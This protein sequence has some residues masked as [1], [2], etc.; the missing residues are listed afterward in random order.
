MRYILY[1]LLVIVGSCTT[2]SREKNQQHTID[3]LANEIKKRDSVEKEEATPVKQELRDSVIPIVI[4]ENNEESK[5]SDAKK[6]EQPLNTIS[7]KTGN[8]DVISKED[9]IVKEEQENTDNINERNAVLKKV[10]IEKPTFKPLLLGG[11][12]E[13][14]FN[15]Y[16]N[17]DYKLEEAIL[18]VHYIRADGSEIKSETKILKDI[19]PH[20]RM[21]LTAPDHAQSGKE[22]KVTLE[23]VHCNAIGLCFYSTDAGRSGD[24]YKCR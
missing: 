14:K 3:S 23:A 17:Y 9:S 12:K 16:N 20:S 24:P 21:E 1:L 6:K 8:V 4:E 7:K 5:V 13:I 10:I 19:S 11:F 2:Y 22:L 15:F 18:K